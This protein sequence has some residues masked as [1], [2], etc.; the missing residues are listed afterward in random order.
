[1]SKSPYAGYLSPKT[2]HLQA[3]TSRSPSTS[4]LTP[5]SAPPKDTTDLVL[6]LQSLY[7]QI[8]SL[9]LQNCLTS[10]DDKTKL[11]KTDLAYSV[12]SAHEDITQFRQDRTLY[13]NSCTTSEGAPIP[14]PSEDTYSAF[15]SSLKST[16]P[17]EFVQ[18][19]SL[20]VIN[21]EASHVQWG[22]VRVTGM[23][24]ES[25]G[26][27][28][29][30]ENFQDSTKVQ[31]KRR[32]KVSSST[33]DSD[34]VAKAARKLQKDLG[35]WTSTSH[36]VKADTLVGHPKESAA[37]VSSKL[38]T[39]T[40][41]EQKLASICQDTVAKPQQLPTSQQLQ[42]TASD[43]DEQLQAQ[44]QSLKNNSDRL[45]S[46]I[47]SSGGQSDSSPGHGQQQ[48]RRSIL[49]ESPLPKH[50]VKADVAGALRQGMM[51]AYQFPPS[52]SPPLPIPLTKNA[53]A[54]ETSVSSTFSE[55]ELES[56][57]TNGRFAPGHQYSSSLQYSPPYIQQSYQ[58]SHS[59]FST[60]PLAR[61]ITRR[62]SS[63]LSIVMNCNDVSPDPTRAQ[64]PSADKDE[65]DYSMDSDSG[66]ASSYQ[67]SSQYRRWSSIQDQKHAFF[68]ESQAQIGVLANQDYKDCPPKLRCPKHVQLEFPAVFYDYESSLT[69][70]IPT[71]QDDPILPYVGNLDLDSGFRGSR[72]FARMPG[73]M[74]IPL[75]GQVQVMIKNPN[76][77]VVKVFLVPYDF[78]DMPA[79]TKTFLRQKYYSTSPG[80]GPVS[81][82]TN[83]SGTLRYA[84]HLQF[85][86]PAPGYVYLYR[87]IRV[88][89]AN[90]VPD[91][92]E[93]LRVVLEGLGMGSRT[94]GDHGK[95]QALSTPA[96]GTREPVQASQK[97]LEERYVKMRKG[98]VSFCSSKRKMDLDSMEL[99]MDGDLLMP[100]SRGL[101]LGLGLDKDYSNS[102]HTHSIFQEQQ[103]QPR[104]FDEQPYTNIAHEFQGLGSQLE[105][106]SAKDLN[107][108]RM[109]RLTGE[110]SPFLMSGDSK[111]VGSGV[112][113]ANMNAEGDFKSIPSMSKDNFPPSMAQAH[114]Q[115][116]I[117]S[118]LRSRTAAV[119]STPT[120]AAR[121][122]QLNRNAAV[123]KVKERS[124]S[125]RLAKLL[126]WVF[127]IHVGAIYLFTRGFLL[128][129]SVLDS[130][131]ECNNTNLDNSIFNPHGQDQKQECWYPQQFKKAI[132][133]VID[134][135]RF[136]F[137]VPHHDLPDD[138]EEPYYLN[139][140]PAIHNLIEKQPD[141]TLVFQFVADPPTTTLQRLKALT[142]GTLPTIID[143]GSNFA[144]SAL[145]EDNWLSQFEASR[146]QD[147]ILF[148]GDDTW[149]GLFPNVLTANNSHSFPS[150]D[151]HDLDTL[152]NGVMK[153][154]GPA[155][156]DPSKWDL[157]VAHF[158]GVDHCGHT[159][160]P[161]DPHMEQKLGQMNDQLEKII[162]SA[163]DDTLVVIMGD[164]GMN[165]H[166]DH[167]GDSDDE[168]EAGLVIYSK[169]KLVNASLLDRLSLGD[170]L[171]YT[172]PIGGNVYRTVTQIDLVPTLSLLLGLPIPFN[173]LG[174][175]IPELFLSAKTPDNAIRDLLRAMQLNAA[176]VS[177]YFNSY[178]ELHPTSDIAL[179]IQTEFGGL[180]EYAETFMTTIGQDRRQQTTENL[181]QAL[182]LYSGYLRTSLTSCKRIWAHFDVPLMAAGGGIL[183]AN[184][185]CL[186]MHIT[187]F[188]SVG[189][190]PNLEKFLAGG[191]LLGIGLA[192]HLKPLLL[193]IQT[194]QESSLGLVDVMIFSMATFSTIGFVLC[195]TLQS[196]TFAKQRSWNPLRL[197]RWPPFSGFLAC[198]FIF[199]NCLIFASNSYIVH[200]STFIVGFLQTF[201]VIGLLFSL[202]V[203]DKVERNKAVVLTLSFMAMARVLSAST[204]CREEQGDL[205]SPTYYASAQ[206]SVPSQ[207]SLVTLV[208]SGVI[209][210]YL[211]R[212]LLSNTK[213]LNGIGLI[214]IDYGLRIGII[215]GTLYA[216]LD[217]EG[218]KADVT[219]NANLGNTFEP[220]MA[221]M[222]QSGKYMWIK[223]IL[224]RLAFGFALLVGP[225][226]WWY[227]P[228]CMDIHAEDVPV[229]A[230]SPNS[231][232]NAA[233]TNRNRRSNKGSAASATPATKRTI[234][235]LGYANAFGASYFV[236]LTMLFLFVCLT[237]KPLGAIVL[238]VGLAMISCL[239]ELVDI[240][241][242]AD[243]AIWQLGIVKRIQSETAALESEVDKGEGEAALASAST[244]SIVAAVMAKHPQPPASNLL[245]PSV[246][247][248]LTGNL[249]FFA[250]GHQATLSSIQW[251]SAFIGVQN[252]NYI[253]S[254]ILVITNTLG[255]FILCAAALPLVVL[256]KL[257]PKADKFG[258]LVLFPELT[259][260]CLM[261]M[262]HQSL[263]LVA[264]MFFTG[265]MFRRHLMVWKVFAPRFMLQAGALLSMDLVL[266]AV[267][268]LVI[269]ARVVKEVAQVLSVHII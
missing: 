136:D 53:N 61:V 83:G 69:H 41:G 98:E 93:S 5:A 234:Y 45:F 73:G 67:S 59:P 63:R 168:V 244:E 105:S 161:N 85:C 238:T 24:D 35:S 51:Q 253:I 33:H 137:V 219:R 48:P 229:E 247:L 191:T 196:Q 78:M 10:F 37:N 202:R 123:P 82:N 174:S 230:N 60:S 241:R 204:V 236:A 92:K 225:I 255:P 122:N 68:S 14:D 124:P 127:L 177:T 117:P 231:H 133:V 129:R 11:T 97:K 267:A 216:V 235:I 264:N 145:K 150:L 146:G 158:L 173:N 30:P 121:P 193:K 15:A 49:Q 178:M 164:H 186:L 266:V 139:K 188:K 31:K 261:M 226:A 65:L 252:L 18:A 189:M 28:I 87:S 81:T 116:G 183:L 233:S 107:T 104:N 134:A 155:L 55:S 223:N 86:C 142:T 148:M 101:G 70:S 259:R 26:G 80:M 125:T 13:G 20:K 99:S 165:G 181:V 90:R 245:L 185:L 169:R 227:S 56:T 263:V 182:R 128:S 62:R 95:S 218:S 21:Y 254:P 1:G 163:S 176:Q 118:S 209:T 240:W 102:T 36:P 46:S 25:V 89:F 166:G 64:S 262:M 7:T 197:I 143:A 47:P 58:H 194:V 201:G 84:I 249:L 171:Q 144:S 212:R 32:S 147:R 76:K 162:K 108:N 44:L 79:G 113:D 54:N 239:I 94:I 42:T 269:L 115:A 110:T 29:A 130:K 192:R 250:T 151:T 149:T 251:S 221:G 109:Q 187:V 40:S 172:K 88:V 265:G 52:P 4:A 43:S 198:L 120:T 3:Q 106:G 34:P 184:C 72:R 154:L 140:L 243:F 228:L 206:Q 131:S 224:V 66:A 214:W 119:P 2:K 208:G 16:L 203:P 141:N 77:T 195:L 160:G 246:V 74:R 39:L 17:L 213:S 71:A 211:I 153:T 217:F 200:E 9:P 258:K 112:L 12:T 38:S 257:P 179:A 57:S 268:V 248:S 135:L 6:L 27:R 50:E 126:L 175:V 260:L 207:W 180:F 256:W 8:R 157:L 100:S 215:L 91:G 237:Q 156:E 232:N 222:N 199:V 19:A 205:C 111:R 75:R 210:P 220:L 170:M 114:A 190:P 22:C 167:G 96:V 103:Q 152:D 242:D 132:V 138:K 159:Y 23:Y